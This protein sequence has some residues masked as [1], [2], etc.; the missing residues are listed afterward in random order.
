MT[1]PLL[2]RTQA[3]L[4]D[5]HYIHVDGSQGLQ[6]RHLQLLADICARDQ[7]TGD[8]AVTEDDKATAINIERIVAEEQNKVEKRVLENIASL[9]AITSSS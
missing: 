6:M 5:V 9:P 1:M 8:A 2:E 3:V 4:S 7:E